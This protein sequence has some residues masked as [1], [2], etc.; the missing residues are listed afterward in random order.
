MVKQ[1]DL[2]EGKDKGPLFVR[3]ELLMQP[4]LVK[5]LHSV[6]PR[7]IMGTWWWNRQRARCYARNNY[8]CFAC[9][10]HKSDA[11]SRKWLEAHESY[12]IDLVNCSYELEELVALC[13]FCH[14]YIHSG[15]LHAVLAKGEI[16]RSRFDAIMRWGDNLLAFNGLDKSTAWWQKDGIIQQFF[17]EHIGTWDKWHLILDGE[18]HYSPF[19]D[20]GAW[21]KKYGNSPE[22][23]PID[24]TNVELP[25]VDD[26][27]KNY[28]I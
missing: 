11:V 1:S 16:S 22:L 9:G 10:T 27:G 15:R 8:H 5:P 23:E 7:N 26:E 17:P 18:K 24:F 14:N 2:Y 20:Y 6:A 28:K 13:H 4:N 25:D 19:K 12:K 3:P 21:A